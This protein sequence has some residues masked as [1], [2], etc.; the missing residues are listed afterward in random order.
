MWQDITKTSKIVNLKA[1]FS[2]SQHGLR[3]LLKYVCKTQE[4]TPQMQ[5]YYDITKGK[6]YFQTF[7]TGYKRALHKYAS[8]S[9]GA[10]ADK[11]LKKVYDPYYD[12]VV[13]FT[14][15][16]INSGN[17]YLFEKYEEEYIF[18]K[19][20]KHKLPFICSGCFSPFKKKQ[21]DYGICLYEEKELPQEINISQIKKLSYSR[22][23]LYQ[24]LELQKLKSLNS[25]A[26][27]EKLIK[28]VVLSET[29]RLMEKISFFL[30]KDENCEEIENELSADEIEYLK[31]SGSIYMSNPFTYRRS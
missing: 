6:R 29:D 26:T 22:L 13:A 28:E 24:E 14:E 1:D 18:Q 7:G 4:V 10:L 30:I 25:L 3:Y 27:Q 2:S 8:Y 20:K 16:E 12:G 9:V 5:E 23:I 11:G 31:L 21:S 17:V 19:K 15:I